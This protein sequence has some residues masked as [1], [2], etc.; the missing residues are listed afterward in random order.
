MPSDTIQ[1]V[2]DF[3]RGFLNDA[4]MEF[5]LCK[6]EIFCFDRSRRG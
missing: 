3:V 2:M 4:T 1:Q 6:V 5:H